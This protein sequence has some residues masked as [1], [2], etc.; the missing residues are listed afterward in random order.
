MA[1]WNQLTIEPKRSFRYLVTFGG[2]FSEFPQA[3]QLSMF[4]TS[5]DRPSFEVSFKEFQYLNH[6]FNY[7]GR[8]KWKEVKMKF[9]D[10][11]GSGGDYINQSD[12]KAAKISTGPV[13]DI[14]KLMMNGLDKS[15]YAVPVDP[16]TNLKTLSK[17]TMAQHVG[18]IQIKVLAPEV[19]TG[20]PVLGKDVIEEWTLYNSMFGSVDFSQLTYDNEDFSTVDLTIRYDYAKIWNTTGA[21][22]NTYLPTGL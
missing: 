13:L 1:F 2:T 12:P 5:V 15:G 9:V 14:A 22:G 20:E 6:Q 8:V 11:G 10:A 3:G 21:G 18:Q 19:A 7:P 4:A 17:A 16:Q